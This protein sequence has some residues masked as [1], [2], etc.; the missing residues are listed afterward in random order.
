MYMN[1]KLPTA[2]ASDPFASVIEV[3]EAGLYQ[4]TV[5]EWVAH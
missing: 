5:T 1:G 4:V 2:Y 3:D